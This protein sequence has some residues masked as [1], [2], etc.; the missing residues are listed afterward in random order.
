MAA[1]RSPS[2]GNLLQGDDRNLGGRR[3]STPPCPDLL[4]HSAVERHFGFPA[5]SRAPQESASLKLV[6]KTLQLGL[7]LSDN[8]WR[9]MS[10]SEL[11]VPSKQ[12]RKNL[13]DVGREVH[14]LT[15]VTSQAQRDRGLRLPPCRLH[16][17]LHRSRA[18][19]GQAVLAQSRAQAPR[20]T[21]YRQRCEFSRW[22]RAVP[23]FL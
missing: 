14:D 12:Y 4:I 2:L 15:L 18:N 23:R 13:V 6:S 17:R 1:L 9:E 10:Q 7:L 16:T 20:G 8:Y 5:V 21:A 19:L 22:R 3:H 11:G